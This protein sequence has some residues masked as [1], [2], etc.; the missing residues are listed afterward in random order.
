MSG[1][2]GPLGATPMYAP[3]AELDFGRWTLRP[4]KRALGFD[5]LPGVL[6]GHAFD[7]LLALV[8]GRAILER[9]SRNQSRAGLRSRP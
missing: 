8:D 2:A 6:G 1:S 7:L 4:A 9:R 5:C 3:G